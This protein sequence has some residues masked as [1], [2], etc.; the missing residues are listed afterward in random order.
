[1]STNFF[2]RHLVKLQHFC[3]MRE[4]INFTLTNYFGKSPAMNN[5][6]K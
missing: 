5:I 1:M 4:T 2:L 6:K 3:Q